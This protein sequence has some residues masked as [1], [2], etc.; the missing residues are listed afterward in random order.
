MTYYIMHDVNGDDCL[1]ANLPTLNDCIL[2]MVQEHAR[3]ARALLSIWTS[4]G[5]MLTP[6]CTAKDWAAV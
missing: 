3:D 6:P 5:R 2:R 1:L 4:D